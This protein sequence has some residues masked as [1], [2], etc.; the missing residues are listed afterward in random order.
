MFQQE[1]RGK[2]MKQMLGTSSISVYVK[3]AAC[4]KWIYKMSENDECHLCILEY[5]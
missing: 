4:D 2:T 3:L 1:P 5:I